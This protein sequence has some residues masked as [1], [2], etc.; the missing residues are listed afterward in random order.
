MQLNALQNIL[1]GTKASKASAEANPAEGLLESLG[2]GFEGMLADL[3]AAVND[4]AEGITDALVEVPEFLSQ[5]IEDVLTAIDEVAEGTPLGSFLDMMGLDAKSLGVKNANDF[6]FDGDEFV[7]SKNQAFDIEAA[8]EGLQKKLESVTKLVKSGLEGDF[9]SARVFAEDLK[10]L[11]PGNKLNNSEMKR[12][13]FFESGDDFLANKELA[14]KQVAAE[15]PYAKL[16]QKNSS[17][18]SKYANESGENAK[19]DISLANSEAQTNQQI[20][21]EAI[22]GNA[23]SSG[24]MSG[25]ANQSQVLDLSGSN[26]AKSTEVINK[27]VNYLDQ[28]QLTSKGELDVIVKHDELG[29]FRLN[30]N[31]GVDKGAVGMQ[32]SATGEGHRFFTEHEVELVKTLNQNG[33]KLT[34]LKIVQSDVIGGSKSSSGSGSFSESSSDGKSGSQFADSQQNHHRQDRNGSDRRKFLWEEYR[35]RMGASA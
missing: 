16:A 6:T 17:M 23:K 33:V 24:D 19:V 29:Q 35:E 2:G 9:E 11:R 12:P 15:T 20:L 31:R 7:N 26:A 13:S 22:T 34:D 14:S 5:K 32:I 18:F 27:I 28:Q 21:A 3:T 30:V 4:T 1:Q 25:K 10:S 8:L